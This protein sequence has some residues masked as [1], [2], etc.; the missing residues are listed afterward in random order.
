MK[1]EDTFFTGSAP[2]STNGMTIRGQLYTPQWPL[3]MGIVNVT[4]DS[5]YAGSRAAGI[6]ACLKIAEK[7]LLAGAHF[8]DLGAVSTRPGA[9]EVDETEEEKRLI[10]CVEAL[11]K[12]FPGALLSVDTWRANIVKAAVQ[13]GAVMVN[14]IT[15]GEGDEKM[16]ETVAQLDVPYI[17]MHTRGNARTM[18]NL[19]QYEYFP[20]DVVAYLANRISKA[21]SAGIKDI[22]IDPG[23]G[24]AKTAEQNFALI[25]ELKQFSIL[26]KP[27]LMGISRK[28]FIYKTLGIEANDALNGTSAL[29]MSC[30][31]NGAKI[32]RVHDVKEAMEVRELYL[33][34]VK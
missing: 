4:P 9:D 12:N 18:Q 32:L 19:T 26:D 21:H 7:Q 14:D 1:R 34:V 28:G 15:A 31:M 13:N 2:L 8:I 20:G 16:L 25:R 29:H 33:Q 24:F 23:I 22:W 3:I 6:D 30:L 17:M 10:P 11:V 27:I 5:F